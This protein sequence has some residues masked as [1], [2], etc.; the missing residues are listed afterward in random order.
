MSVI[1]KYLIVAVSFAVIVTAGANELNASRFVKLDETKKLTLTANGQAQ[2]EIIVPDDACAV[3]RFA[4]KELQSFLEQSSGTKIPLVSKAAEN[5]TEIIIGDNSL[6]RAA[7]IDVKALPRDGFIIKSIS[8]RIYIAGRDDVKTEPEK[9]LNSGYWGLLHERGTL[10]GVYDFLERFAGVRFYFPGEFGTIIPEHKTLTVS[11]MDI[12][13]RPDYT[14][15]KTSY[16]SGKWYDSDK[17]KDGLHEKN[18]NYY[19]TRQETEYIP[20]CHGLSRLG[21]LTR[22]GESH[23]EYFALMSNGL[24]HN[25]PALPHPGQLCLSSGIREEIYKDAEAFLTGKTAEERGV[26]TARFGYC[27][28]PSALQP[29]YFNIMPQDS[30]FECTC[31]ECQKHFSKGAQATSDFIWQFVIDTALRLKKNGIP[32]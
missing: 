4:A 2:C 15:R 19:R 17:P 18:L 16:A 1:A 8:N 13:E 14:V 28:D 31:P 10:F 12:V 29:G 22:F 6:S 9:V 27:W 24:R 20:N 5:K 26:K 23:P 3:A 21:Y 11:A 7:G 30:F 25:N 32:G